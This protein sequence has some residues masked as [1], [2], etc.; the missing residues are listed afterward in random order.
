MQS[1]HPQPDVNPALLT[2]RR[3]VRLRNMPADMPPEVEKPP[4]QE[5]VVENVDVSWSVARSDYAPSSSDLQNWGRLFG[6]EGSTEVVELPPPPRP[7]AAASTYAPRPVR[8]IEL[9]TGISYVSS[10]G[11]LDASLTRASSAALL[12]QTSTGGWVA[13]LPQG[14]QALG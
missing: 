12:R 13:M 4:A 10:S 8:P 9:S 1:E 3:G 5:V 6:M 14:V 2:G 11:W 7:I